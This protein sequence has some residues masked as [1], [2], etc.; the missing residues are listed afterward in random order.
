MQKLLLSLLAVSFATGQLLCAEDTAA[1]ATSPG[2][3]IR[4]FCIAAPRP[5][6]LPRFLDFINKELGPRGVNTLILR[7]DYNY[8]FQ[9]HPELAEKGALSLADVKQLVAA[10]RSHHID[11]IPQIDLLGHQGWESHENILLRQYPQF[12]ETP[13]VKNPEHYQWPN[14]DGLYCRSYCPLQPE[15]HKVLFAVIDELCDAFESD[16]FHAGMDEVFYIGESK[17]PRCGGRNKA[18][19][20]A[21]EVTRLD[22]HLK[23]KGRALW[24][25]G[26]RLLDG[27]TTG[28]GEW[29]AS[30]NGTAPAIDWIP[31]DVII[32]D[33]HYDRPDATALYF[34]L[35]GF[36]VVACPW[37]QAWVGV[38]DA[39]DLLEWRHTQTPAVQQRL[40]GITLTVW[41]GVGNFLD[42][43]YQSDP[44]AT[45]AWNCLT[46]TLAEINKR[47]KQPTEQGRAGA[48][49]PAD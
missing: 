33:W 6:E 44:G 29:E 18:E 4:G 11:L 22:D 3:P 2:L 15:L 41:S 38:Q 10:C 32:C 19:L 30:Y 39:D 46:A 8:Q 5:K 43:D 23:E 24:I 12:D 25:W 45:N 35:K 31:R 36:K 7:V 49:S 27:H 40:L 13:W 20:F 47:S 26:D 28:L 21:G 37:K 48:A 17:C 16:A 1:T 42:R 14:P 34:A 9:S